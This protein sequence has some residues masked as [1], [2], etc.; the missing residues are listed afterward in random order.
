MKALR[1]AGLALAIL[2]GLLALAAAALFALFD[3]E[4]AKAELS[5]Q[6]LTQTQRKLTIEGPLALSV[7]PDVALRLPRTT[8]SERA[9]D[10]AFASLDAARI[11]V[12]VLPLLSRRIEVRRV[13]LDGLAVTVIKRKDGRLNIA[14]LTAQD[15]ADG[16]KVSPGGTALPPSPAPPAT[17]S[18]PASATAP[19]H[20]DIAGIA[21]RNAQLHWRDEASGQKVDLSN[22]ALTS[23]RIE[24]DT[25]KARYRVEQFALAAKGSQGQER[26]ELSLA[27]PAMEI[28]DN[29]IAAA[30]LDLAARLDGNGRQVDAKLTLNGLEGSPKAPRIR[31]LALEVDAGAGETRLK[32][33]LASPVELDAQA[34]TVALTKLDG[35]LDISGP[36]MPAKQLNL[37][38]TGSLRADI[39]KQHAQLAVSTRLD[40][41]AIALKLAVTRFAPPAITFDLDVDRL[42][43]DKYL[44]PPADAGAAPQPA[45]A[46]AKGDARLD[47]S[48]LKGH[49]VRGQLRIGELRA[50][51]IQ[52]AKVAAKIAL[53]GGRL[54][55]APLTAQLY[56]GTLEGSLAADANGNAVSVRQTLNGIDIAPLLRDAIG[57]DPVEGRGRVQ[58]DLGGRGAT[59][60]ALKKS[61]AG[62]AS[63]ALKDGAVKG[64]N[65]AKSL[66]EI[67]AR[68]GAKQDSSA[69]ANG[70]EKTDFSELSASFRVAG[71]VARNDDLL[72][73][74]PFLRLSGAGDIDLGNERIDYLAKV[75][76]VNTAGGQEGKDLEHLK[77]LTLPVRLA[78]PFTQLSYK[79]E[80]G[81]LVEEAAKAKV[82]AKK[83]EIKTRAEDQLKG[84]LKGLF[85]K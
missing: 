31:N 2:I 59:V 47:L 35:K 11:A 60:P 7:W 25:S 79:L 80:L 18:P 4:K 81:G 6:V 20:I 9:S 21:V 77:G 22:L 52:A 58:V 10:A 48:A 37:P 38:L 24:G 50:R 33:R 44:P 49:D 8:L 5:A 64:I 42:D 39:P 72:M 29:A 83:E 53:A 14:D 3:G 41:S 71:G 70:A 57:K 36:A 1:I 16:A 61:L 30:S 75:S 15:A 13:E 66:R 55:V 40:D 26:F 43:L 17:S 84:K 65:L 32:G 63:L 56:G 74:S 62:S 54:E 67:K 78:G 34:Q 23:G 28:A 69:A 19:L 76:V 51:R 73:K 82:E 85:G 45:A 68:L 12:A 46:E 27:A